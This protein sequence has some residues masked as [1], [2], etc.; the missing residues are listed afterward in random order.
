V[1]TVLANDSRLI[2]G[3]S[4]ATTGYT[5]YSSGLVKTVTNP[6][7]NTTT[8]TYGDC[9]NSFLTNVA[10][11]L[12]LS[13]SMTW[14]C[15]GEVPLTAKDEN[16]QGTSY[17]YNDALWRLTEVDSPDGGQVT[18]SYNDAA[19]SVTT[20]TVIDATIA[21]R[22]WKIST[23]KLTDGLGRVKQTQLTTDPAGTDF[24]DTTYDGLGRVENRGVFHFV[25]FF[26]E[27]GLAQSRLAPKTMKPAQ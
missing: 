23:T 14:D 7:H 10:E 27:F 6:N 11:P 24:T 25:H 12:N 15:N 22:G 16:S 17:V 5:Y 20:T 3:S 26:H 21:P 1:H 8:Y 4:Y 13:R 18:Y 9:N 19:P 2:H